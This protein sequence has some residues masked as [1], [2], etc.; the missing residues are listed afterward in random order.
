MLSGVA[1]IEKLCQAF[2]PTGCEEPVARLIREELQ[3]TRAELT[4]DRMGNLV[5][6]LPGPAGAL[7]V[8]LSAHMDEVGFMITDIEEKGF[9]RFFRLGG[10]DPRVLAGRLV[11]VGDG[12]K[13]VPGIIAALGIH[14]TTKEDRKKVPDVDDLFIDIGVGSREE[15]EKLVAIGDFAAFDSPFAA[16]GQNDG[17]LK[18]KAL[19]DRAGC[20]VLI[21]AL[22]AVEKAGLPLDLYFCFTVREE[23]GLSGAAVT[24]HRIAPD[25]SF[26]IETTAIADLPGVPDARQVADVG[27]GGVLSLLDN[28]TIY[29]RDLVNFALATGQKN[30]IP[31]QVKR[32]VSGGNDAKHIQRS[33]SGV[34]CMALSAP[35]RYLHAPVSVAALSDITAIRDLLTAMLTEPSKEGNPLCMQH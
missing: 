11:N 16:F 3:N 4:S 24:A 30:G 20:A 17:W 21:E 1:L 18:G 5:A 13:T 14:F 22:R 31:V 28:G 10:I 26:V 25:F 12:E 29:D 2:G 6:H 8:M 32:Y 15:A 35:T 34:R 27:K 19:D 33:G 9:L 23:I 7:R